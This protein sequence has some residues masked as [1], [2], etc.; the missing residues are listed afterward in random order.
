[1]YYRSPMSQRLFAISVIAFVAAHAAFAGG[2]SE[3]V[4][5][6]GIVLGTACTVTVYDR[7]P[8]RTL[9]EVFQRLD[10]IEAEM[11]ISYAGTEL[12]TLNAEAGTGFHSVSQ[13]TFTVIDRALE[14]SKESSGRFDLT[15]GPLVNLWGIG[16]DHARLPSQEEI[17]AAKA[18][19]GY[20]MVSIKRENHEVSLAIPG[21]VIDLGGIGK[22][23][24]A[25][26]AAK[27]IRAAGAERA[28]INLGG[29]VLAMGEKAPGTPWRVG[30]QHPDRSRG[31]IVGVIEV[32]N[33]TVVTS[34]IYERYFEAGGK[35]YHHILDPDTG[36]PVDNGLASVSVVTDSSMDADA[37]STI[38]FAEGLEKGMAFA[39]ARDNVE[40]IFIDREDHIYLSSG[41]QDNFELTDS[42]F[43]VTSLP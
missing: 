6:S 26:E 25:D 28:I 32:T 40:A 29:N 38:L 41:L 27:I 9:D 42:E 17:D 33:K 22:G 31:A 1:M 18:L 3:P 13:D 2:S 36:Y 19:V 20:E 16:T 21:M 4:R 8:A 12:D 37:L 43:E 34:G 24:A 35:R 5:K 23:Y 11:S 7:V 39:E 30:V 15:I 14:F 10:D